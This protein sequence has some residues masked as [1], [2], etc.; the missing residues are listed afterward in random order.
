MRCRS[1]LSA[2]RVGEMRRSWILGLLPAVALAVGCE[3]APLGPSAA[4][5]LFAPASQPL[6]VLTWQ[7]TFDRYYSGESFV[8]P[9]GIFQA[10]DV[11]SGYVVTGDLEGYVHMVGNGMLDLRTG[12]GTSS[13]TAVYELTEPGVGTLEC[14]WKV[15]RYDLPLSRTYSNWTCS[16]TGYYEGW[17]VKAEGTNEANPGSSQAIIT[18]EVR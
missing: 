17:K 7:I 1:L 2:L 8:T 4:D 6:M 12:H 16:G 15:K 14:V 9:S 18:A 11:D 13:G 10:R 5:P 3:E